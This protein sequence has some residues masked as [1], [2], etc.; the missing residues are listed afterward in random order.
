LFA[1]AKGYGRLSARSALL[2]AL[3]RLARL[4]TR[5]FDALTLLTGRAPASN[6]LEPDRRAR[7]AP[8]RERRLE[9]TP[10]ATQASRKTGARQSGAATARAWFPRYRLAAEAVP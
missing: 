7:R 5:L 9:C 8:R 2:A 4:M 3:P 6:A 1:H 10:D